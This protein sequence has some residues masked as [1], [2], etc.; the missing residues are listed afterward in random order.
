MTSLKYMRPK[1]SHGS[2]PMS[3]KGGSLYLGKKSLWRGRS[4]AYGALLN[5]RFQWVRRSST[6]SPSPFFSFSS[7]KSSK[8]E[9]TGNTTLNS[10]MLFNNPCT[11]LQISR[12]IKS[13]SSRH[14]ALIH[15]WA[16]IN[17]NLSE[18]HL[19]I[20]SAASFRSLPPGPECTQMAEG[21]YLVNSILIQ[22]LLLKVQ[23]ETS[24]IGTTWKL[25]RIAETQTPLQTC[26][27]L[28][29]QSEYQRQDVVT[30]NTCSRSWLC[31]GKMGEL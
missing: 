16:C 8:L 20:Q 4:L 7:T 22:S 14:Q 29:N 11:L 2:F 27:S 23:P 18:L 24:I 17:C 9:P 25:I 3:G 13:P 21:F 5:F 31:I 10:H 28:G 19:S 30:Q 12:E 26:S 15:M 6:P 1:Q